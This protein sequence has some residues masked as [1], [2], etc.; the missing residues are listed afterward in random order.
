MMMELSVR[1]SSVADVLSS[2]RS[3]P[4]RIVPYATATALTRSAMRAR[5]DVRAAM[6]TAFD[7]PTAYTLNSLFVQ[8]ATAQALRARVNVKDQPVS[9]GT[10]QENYLLPEVE[11]GARKNKRIENALRYAGWLP[12]GWH[13]VTTR[14]A[15]SLLD[16]YGN[17]PG[18]IVR[19]ILVACGART[20]KTRAAHRAAAEYF[21]IAP[22]QARGR[23]KPGVYKRIGAGRGIIPVLIFTPAQP[24]YKQR[25]DF[26]G[27]A[28]RSAESAFAGEF[29]RALAAQLAKGAA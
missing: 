25:L 4:A 24:N 8:P 27:I 21:A 9:G 1:S 22:D 16:A 3:V 12:A 10:A 2:L 7:R 15:A 26:T 11:G 19:R 17:L 13:A 29:A 6:Q 23:L 14:A 28:Q 18:S 5:D 20:V